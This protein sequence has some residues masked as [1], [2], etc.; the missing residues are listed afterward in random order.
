MVSK[1]KA[2]GADGLTRA[3]AACWE[4]L[5]LAEFPGPACPAGCARARLA[6]CRDHGREYTWTP[7]ERRAAKD[8]AHA[9]REAQWP[10][11]IRAWF[12]DGNAKEYGA[13]LSRLPSKGNLAR[14]KALVDVPLRPR[15]AQTSAC[16]GDEWQPPP[17][18]TATERDE[19]AAEAR[20]A[21]EAL[22]RRLTGGTAA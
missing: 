19:A 14:I 4:P 8:V 9:V 22:R 12:A 2:G 16:T 15:Q 18:L 1:P 10:A 5:W 7:S 17:D 6:V 11:V 20:A 13:Q 3:F 21:C